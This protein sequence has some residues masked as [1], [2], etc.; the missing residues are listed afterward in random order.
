MHGKK[1]SEGQLLWIERLLLVA[2]TGQNRKKSCG[3]GSGSYSE[4]SGRLWK[5]RS[6]DKEYLKGRT[7]VEVG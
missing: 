7:S 5:E 6:S 2:G 4:V 3:N 1:K